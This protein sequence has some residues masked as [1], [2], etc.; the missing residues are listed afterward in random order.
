[1]K[2]YTKIVIALLLI[3]VFVFACK[4]DVEKSKE[5]VQPEPEAPVVEEPVEVTLPESEE[6]EAV[7]DVAP[8]KLDMISEA[9]C[10]DNNI[11]VVLTNPT[12]KV[13]TFAK[14]AKIIINGLV[15]VDPECD[16]L[17]LEPGESTYCTD[18]SGHLA[19]RQGA[20]NRIQVNMF[21]ERG[22]SDIKCEG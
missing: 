5:I 19:I 11:E 7:I 21:S 2:T 22:L 12:E 6:G 16:K 10:I 9:R 4:K 13:L 17:T 3:L 14:D 8:G 20:V 15:V 1:M 18:I